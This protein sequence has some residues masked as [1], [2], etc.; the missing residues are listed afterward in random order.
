MKPST[1]QE[2]KMGTTDRQRMFIG[3]VKKERGMREDVYC[4]ASLEV[5]VRAALPWP[6]FISAPITSS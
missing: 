4:A 6:P 1:Q 5:R 2:D 3:R